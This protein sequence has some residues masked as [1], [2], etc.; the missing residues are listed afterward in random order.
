MY[1]C[2][3]RG[4]GSWPP[5]PLRQPLQSWF[6]SSLAVVPMKCQDDVVYDNGWSL[7]ALSFSSPHSTLVRLWDVRPQRSY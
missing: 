4:G 1:L 2:G 6:V 7:P 3:G 5:A